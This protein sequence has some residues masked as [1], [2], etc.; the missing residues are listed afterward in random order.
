LTGKIS[1]LEQWKII[2][3]SIIKDLGYTYMTNI[4]Y[5]R[6]IIF[7]DLSPKTNRNYHYCP[8]KISE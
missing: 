8:V 7:W 3:K 1:I 6:L 4:K 5:K 2:G